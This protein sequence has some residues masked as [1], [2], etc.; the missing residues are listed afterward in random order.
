MHDTSL[1]STPPQSHHTDKPRWWTQSVE[2]SWN[3]VKAQ[4]LQEWE[5]LV[6]GSKQ[7]DRRLAEEALAFGHGARAGYHRIEIWGRDL[8]SRL[9]QDWKEMSRNVERKWED[10]RDA[11][12][13]GWERARGATKTDPPACH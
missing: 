11:V 10:V 3:K 4:V 1:E 5:K 12:K 8:E 6:A 13:L 2:D 9:Q 7:L